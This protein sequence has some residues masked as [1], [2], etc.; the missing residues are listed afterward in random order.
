MVLLLEI[1]LDAVAL[2][3]LYRRPVATVTFGNKWIWVAVIVLINLIGAILYFAIGRKSAQTVERPAA[4]PKRSSADIA[5][6]LYG[7]PDE[8]KQQ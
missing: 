4:E 3:D 5:D 1:A 2:V 8:P 6:A 7:T